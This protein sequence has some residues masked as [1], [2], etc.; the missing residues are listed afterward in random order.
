MGTE[1]TDP[2]VRAARRMAKGLG[3]AGV[4]FLVAGGAAPLPGLGDSL[5]LSAADAGRE[6]VRWGRAA[7]GAAI[8][9]L[10]AIGVRKR[11]RAGRGAATATDPAARPPGPDDA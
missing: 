10:L 3:L 2:R 7:V 4:L 9:V 11:R 1:H 8:V 5:A 6:V